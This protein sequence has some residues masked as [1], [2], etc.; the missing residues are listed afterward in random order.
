MARLFAN[1]A[2]STLAVAL[3]NAATSLSVQAGD[4]AKFPTPAN[5]DYFNLTLV[6]RDANGVENA[7]EI[8]KVTQRSVDTLTITRA[9]EGTAAAAWGVGTPSQLRVSAS[10]FNNF[11]QLDMAN[12]F[13][14]TNI[15]TGAGGCD[16]AVGTSGGPLF[17]FATGTASQVFNT[18]NVPLALG[19]NVAQPL[20]FGTNGA[21]RARVTPTGN[22]L[23][24]STADDGANKLQV[25]GQIGSTVSVTTATESVVLQMRN[26]ASVVGSIRS[27]NAGS[28]NQ[29]MRF[30]TSAGAVPTE[31]MVMT[32]DAGGNVGI[33]H[34][35]PKGTLHVGKA[36]EPI[37]YVANHLSSG[38]ANAKAGSLVFASSYSLTGT[39]YETGRID[40]V[41]AAGS[42]DIG[43][44]IF[45][46]GRAGGGGAI[47]AMRLTANGN[48][49]VNLTAD[50]NSAKVNVN[51]PIKATSFL[52]LTNANVVA[53][54]GFTPI[55]AATK[56]AANG[57][58]PLG[59]DSKIAAVY[60]PSY[61]DDVLEYANL[62]GFPA[63]GASGIIYVADDTGKIYRWSGS[64]YIEISP[65][66]GSTDAVTEGATNLY[67]TA[68]RVLNTV[69]TGLSTA[70]NAVVAATDSVL[71]AIGKL[72]AQVTARAMKGA[73]SDITQ[74]TGLTTAL[75]IGQGGTGATTAATALAALGGAPLASPNFTT[76][77]QI[78]GL[79]IGLKD[80]VQ[81]VQNA[82]Y[83][84]VVGD[85][86]K[87]IVMGAAGGVTI[88]ANVF[89]AGAV[90]TIYNNVG[91]A[92]TI[93][94]GAGLT[95]KFGQP[96][97]SGNRTL[98][99]NGICTVMFLSATAATITGNGLT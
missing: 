63:T 77:A 74:L 5:G 80:A 11:A 82:A 72:Q 62:A 38:L 45:S 61:V 9:Q 13:G 87:C 57:V 48:L 86:G 23:I 40:V 34:N 10:E 58:V 35:A 94:Q 17:G 3:T 37:L 70:A 60:M 4:G 73:N 83:S 65:S 53:G 88:P 75:S 41:T 92:Q 31:Y 91:S 95:L 50:D 89:A 8:V 59:A 39:Y 85:R 15:F 68:A 2:T 32:L 81:N 96:A 99:D 24:N 7:W 29:Q 27:Y 79:D 22:L 71:V 43:Q 49:L 56:G 47:E 30:Y 19:T 78:G 26:G 28:Y 93:T 46:T 90:I 25:N 33:G 20:V 76:N 21:E 98:A 64:A 1:N 12:T 36:G 55:D 52:G 18:A 16:V 84:L 67:F 97:G 51:G 54:L 14:K 6:G 44:M 66:P 42:I 69:L